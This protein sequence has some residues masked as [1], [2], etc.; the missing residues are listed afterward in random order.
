MSLEAKVIK[1]EWKFND[2]NMKQCRPEGIDVNENKN[3][4][5]NPKVNP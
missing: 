5:F 4:S 3:A 1:Y 2:C